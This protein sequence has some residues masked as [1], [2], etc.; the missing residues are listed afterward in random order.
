MF[1][2]YVSLSHDAQRFAIYMYRCDFD[3]VIYATRQTCVA[4]EYRRIIYRS[5]VIAMNINRCQ[6]ILYIF[7]I[8]YISLLIRFT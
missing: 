5:T 4:F 6:A 7:M 3:L 2:L 8:F 1:I